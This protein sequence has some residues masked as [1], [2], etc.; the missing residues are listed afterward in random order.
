MKSIFIF[1][2]PGLLRKFHIEIVDKDY[3]TWHLIGWQH[4]QL[5]AM[6]ENFC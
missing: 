3:L 4:S 2:E 5:E 1:L 6:L